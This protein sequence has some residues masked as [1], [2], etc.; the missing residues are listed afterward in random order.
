MVYI[1]SLVKNR[2]IR[3]IVLTL[4]VREKA[5]TWD[6]AIVSGKVDV[7]CGKESTLDWELTRSLNFN[8]LWL[9]EYG[10][11][12]RKM[13]VQCLWRVFRWH[14]IP[15]LPPAM[16]MPAHHTSPHVHMH[17]WNGNQE[18]NKIS[19]HWFHFDPCKSFSNASSE[20]PSFALASVMLDFLPISEIIICV[21]WNITK[22]PSKFT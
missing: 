3:D 16:S 6:K 10:T 5:K 4:D 13:N 17:T 19:S 12:Q 2:Q 14:I 20:I 21:A 8:I 1:L 9:I 22:I 18:V 15:L 7:N 11:C